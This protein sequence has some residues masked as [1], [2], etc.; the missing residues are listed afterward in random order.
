MPY[1][2]SVSKQV[3]GHGFFKQYPFIINFASYEMPTITLMS[4][5]TLE[6]GILGAIKSWVD[7]IVNFFLRTFMMP[8]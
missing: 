5:L 8:L 3:S 2:G 7:V 6:L 4:Q 1:N